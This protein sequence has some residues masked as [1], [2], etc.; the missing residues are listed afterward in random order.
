MKKFKNYVLVMVCI[1]LFTIVTPTKIYSLIDCNGS[2]QGYEGT[3]KGLTNENNTI[4]N[5]ITR[6]A[7]YYLAAKSDI[8]TILKL[9]ELQNI[10]GLDYKG[11]NVVIESALTNIKSAMDSYKKVIAEAETIPYNE[12]VQAKLKSFDYCSFM[13]IN[14]LNPYI[15][16]EVSNFL[17]KGDITG[18]FKKSHANI[19]HIFDLLQVISNQ[20][21]LNKLPDVSI[22]WQLNESLCESS[23]F[24][25]YV[26]RVFASLR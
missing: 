19:V 8:E 6:G 12:D 4:A 2:G 9:I 22:F 1:V 24:G 5:Y 16:E 26:A 15:F 10:K 14:R 20:A 7:G 3:G 23:M 17:Q 13:A 18:V 11:L 25:S 21:S